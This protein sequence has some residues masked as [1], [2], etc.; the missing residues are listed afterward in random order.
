MSRV[1]LGAN[2]RAADLRRAMV[3]API[4]RMRGSNGERRNGEARSVACYSGPKP[5][6]TN[7]EIA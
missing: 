3:A 4:L 2:R 1:D 5:A 7:P 6:L